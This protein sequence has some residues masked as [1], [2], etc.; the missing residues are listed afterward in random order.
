LGET[1]TGKPYVR[2]TF[3]NVSPGDDIQPS[4]LQDK[5]GNQIDLTT[6]K[7][8]TRGL[9]DFY[10]NEESQWRTR[11]FL[12]SLGIPIEGRSWNETIPEA[13]NQPVILTVAIEPSQ[14]GTQFFN[15]VKQVSAQK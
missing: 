7:P 10:L 4:D 9:S 1:K 8:S 2:F 5:D 3:G 14:D 15:A 12:E 6:W 11:E 13:R